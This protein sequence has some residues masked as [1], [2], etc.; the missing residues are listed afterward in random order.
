MLAFFVIMVY[1]NN[2]RNVL[3]GHISPQGTTSMS[4]ETKPFS[5]S[6]DEPNPQSNPTE[7]VTAQ[8]IRLQVNPD[9]KP[10]ILEKLDT[11]GKRFA[12]A[13]TA[14]ALTLGAGVGATKMAEAISDSKAVAEDPAGQGE[15]TTPQQT[16]EP[17]PLANPSNIA[18]LETTAPTS[19][20][21]I[22]GN[23]SPQT[24][25][26]PQSNNP[27]Q[28]TPAAE[29]G[30]SPA[31][32]NALVDSF[33]ID[34][35]AHPTAESALAAFNE[36]MNLYFNGGNT[37]EE[38]T[39]FY[40][41]TPPA[42]SSIAPGWNSRATELYSEAIQDALFVPGYEDTTYSYLPSMKETKS[43]ASALWANSLKNS[44]TP[45]TLN[46]MFNADNGIA[47]LSNG[48][49]SAFGSTT[50]TDNAANI[51]SAKTDSRAIFSETNPKQKLTLVVKDGQW[52]VDSIEKY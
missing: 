1:S 48:N 30:I 32:Y 29:F 27:E 12:A 19:G 24:E 21:V 51:P 25:T 28:T 13:L 3:C 26:S 46:Y 31:E 16:T 9:H 37:A 14:I 40:T 35:A 36:K 4:I 23:K 50:F 38:R 52:L 18:P 10:S 33:K 17:T 41:W 43:N 39:K 44:E 22:P 5:S 45:Y 20:T 2:I 47:R 15:A 42:G 34:I 49:F 6:N 11:K 8:D 7:Q